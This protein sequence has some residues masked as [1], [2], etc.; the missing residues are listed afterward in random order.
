MVGIPAVV[1]RIDHED[2]LAGFNDGWLAFAGANGGQELEPLRIL[3]RP[4]WDFLADLTTKHLY[5]SMVQRVRQG[6]RPV[7]FRFRC[8]AASR[9]RL[10]AMEITADMVGGAQF[11]VTSVQEEPRQSVPLLEPEHGREARLLSMCGWC[12]RILLPTDGWVEVE[13]AVGA[14]GLF[15]GAP[16]PGI[17]HGMCPTCY[18]AIAG[19]LDDPAGGA[20]G[21][22]TLGALPVA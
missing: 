4:L 20:A 6:G 13:E 2:R 5:R 10:L 8:D 1:Y 22:I 19:E 21:T 12:K 15:G 17:T 16:L 3:G 7:R 9:R 14:L 11:R 18:S